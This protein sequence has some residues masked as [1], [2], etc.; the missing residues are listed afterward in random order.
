MR[1]QGLATGFIAVTVVVTFSVN[2]GTVLVISTGK[3]LAKDE[4]AAK[5]EMDEKHRELHAKL[6]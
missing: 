3:K 1:L 5:K 2:P 4:K 6:Q